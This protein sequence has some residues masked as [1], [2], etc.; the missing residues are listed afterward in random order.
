MVRAARR[1]VRVLGTS[2]GCIGAMGLTAL[3]AM[4][5]ARVASERAGGVTLPDDRVPL[6]WLTDHRSYGH[7]ED[8]TC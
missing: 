7:V 5:S 4:R 6:V 1:P 2:S 3:T 8:G